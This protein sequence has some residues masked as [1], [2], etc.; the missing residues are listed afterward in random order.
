MRNRVSSP[1]LRAGVTPFTAVAFDVHS[2]CARIL[3]REAAAAG[4]PRISPFTMTMIS[5]PRQLAMNKLQIEDDSL[6]PRI[7]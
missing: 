2:L 1:F 3:R 4:L 5:L 7:V 6:S